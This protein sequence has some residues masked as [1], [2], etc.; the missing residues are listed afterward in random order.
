MS[1]LSE[2][3]D[4]HETE[5]NRFNEN[6]G[7]QLGY[8]ATRSHKDR[9]ELLAVIDALSELMIQERYMG[10]IHIYELQEILDK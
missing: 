4:R 10:A 3:R 5:Q 9:G 6:R 1:K 8:G 7:K 2:I